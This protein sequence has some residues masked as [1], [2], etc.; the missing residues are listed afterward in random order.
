MVRGSVLREKSEMTFVADRCL[1]DEG[2][3]DKLGAQG[4]SRWQ[5]E[6]AHLVGPS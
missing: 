2:R 6:G 3:G 1:K 4:E 5:C